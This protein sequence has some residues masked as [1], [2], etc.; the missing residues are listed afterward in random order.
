M[1][2]VQGDILEV[3][4]GY[5]LQ[6]C[7]CVTVHPRGLSA[8]LEQT[9]PKTCPYKLRKPVISGWNI[10]KP[11]D[12]SHPGT[13]MILGNEHGPQ[14]I[15]MFA[16]YGPGKV[17]PV[18][19]PWYQITVSNSPIVP[20]QTTDREQYFAKCLEALYDYFEFTEDKVEIAVPYKIGCGLAGGDWM[21]Y[22]KMLEDFE[23]KI[24]ESGVH[25]EM[26]V[27]CL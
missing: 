16:Q 13:V 15:S 5:I 4:N 17:Q 20:D 8:D 14:I 24:I 1:R 27:Y 21:H 12:I 2:Y 3:K 19:K 10:A 18:N 9:F 7:N 26:T 23:A 25:L 22:R 11:E 6:Q